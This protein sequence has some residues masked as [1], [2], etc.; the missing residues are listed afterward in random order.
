MHRVPG[1]AAFMCA[2]CTS[3]SNPV[4]GSTGAIASKLCSH[5]GLGLDVKPAANR[6]P[7]VGASLLAKA[8]AQPTSS[9]ADPPLSRASSL[10]Q[11]IGAG[12]EVC[13]QPRTQCGSKACSRWRRHIQHHH[14][15]IHRF[16]EQARS[17][18]GLVVDVKSAA[19]REPS[20]G[21][22]LLAMAAAHP[23]SSQADPPLSRASFAP[24]RGFGGWRRISKKKPAV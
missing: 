19:N 18:R 8:A 14:S 17:H 2:R 4:Y 10:P 23:T 21:A 3:S 24:T 11:G 22:S 7:S 1:K 16:R 20:V 12:C 13:V 6:E 9:Q 15:L 5:R